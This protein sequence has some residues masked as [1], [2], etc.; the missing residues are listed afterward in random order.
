M[1]TNWSGRPPHI[2]VRDVVGPQAVQS[3]GFGVSQ[4]Y[5]TA[6]TPTPNPDVTFDANDFCLLFASAWTT[7]IT[8]SITFASPWT[9]ISG[10][11]IAAGAN[12]SDGIM[13]VGRCR[14]GDAVFG[15][16]QYSAPSSPTNGRAF[17]LVLR[18]VRIADPIG[19]VEIDS[20]TSDATVGTAAM[21]LTASGENGIVAAHYRRL[22]S[23]FFPLLAYPNAP[24]STIGRVAESDITG[25][26]AV[27]ISAGPVTTQ[28]T[29]TATQGGGTATRVIVGIEIKKALS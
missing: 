25:N 23:S 13:A 28:G 18:G 24:F 14:Y 12:A 8:N 26:F 17:L 15:A 29:I 19:D 10:T 9:A 11:N 22:S 21:T 27:G 20:G 1:W 3:V 5:G 4:T 7:A 16:S 6:P 2:P